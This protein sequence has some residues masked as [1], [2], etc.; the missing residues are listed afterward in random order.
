MRGKVAYSI[1]GKEMFSF[2]KWCIIIFL[3]I[4]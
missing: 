3:K 2:Y 4:V 1:I